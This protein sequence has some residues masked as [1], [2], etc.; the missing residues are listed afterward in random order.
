MNIAYAKGDFCFPLAYAFRS[1]SAPPKI[2]S[3]NIYVQNFV[4]LMLFY[5]HASW[6][7][8]FSGYRKGLYTSGRTCQI[9]FWNYLN[10]YQMEQIWPGIEV[11]EV[12]MGPHRT[13]KYLEV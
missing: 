9:R 5:F 6:T 8:Q 3:A 7:I 11:M 1:V 2:L 12:V 4:S 13:I 10:I